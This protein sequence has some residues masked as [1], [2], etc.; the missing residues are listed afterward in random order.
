MDSQADKRPDGR[1]ILFIT[2]HPD[3]SEFS[4]AGSA[5]KWAR[6][7]REVSYC[8]VTNGD[9]GSADPEA[10]CEQIAA[11]RAKEQRAACN[12]IGGRDLIILGYP[13]G[14]LQNTIDVRRDIVRV[15]RRLKPDVVVCQDPTVRFRGNYINHPDHR[16]AGDA[17]L[18][19][20]F[21]SAR[22]HLVFPELIAEG[23][24]PHKVGEVLLTGSLEPDL[25]IDIS[26]TIDAKVAALECHASQVTGRD[27]ATLVRERAQQ[28]GHVAGFAYA[29]C[30]R[31]LH[32]Q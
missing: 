1:R 5:A 16:A 6:E 3:D 7:G 13:D 27:V 19:A 17:A 15:I 9:K 24:L 8:I 22:D 21:P 12:A 23:L 25:Y 11:L 18:D 32:L 29:E 31:Y 20:V 2:A 10:T 28:T 4:A 30:F 14:T 26:E